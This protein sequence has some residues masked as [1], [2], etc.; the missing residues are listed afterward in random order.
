MWNQVKKAYEGKEEDIHSRLM[1]QNYESIPQ[2]WFY[3]VLFSMAGLAI[4]TCQAF[5]EQVQLSSWGF[6]IVFAMITILLFP[7]AVLT[8]TTNTVR[9]IHHFPFRLKYYA[10]VNHVTW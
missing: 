3:L 10:V 1:K 4:L 9:W 2:W 5:N 8:A 6:L 7:N